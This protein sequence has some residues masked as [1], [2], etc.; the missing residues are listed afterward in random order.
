M[1]TIITGKPGHGKTLYTLH[2][3]QKTFADS[4]RPIYQNG[5]PDL[6][7]PWL[8]LE[9]PNLWYEL[10]EGSVIVIDEAQRIF[11]NRH[12]SAAVPQKVREFET[13][14]H[15]GFDVILI[16]QD[17]SLIDFAVRKLAGEHFHVRRP[18]GVKYATVS[19]WE[20]CQSSPNRRDA[21]EMAVKERWR[22]PKHLFDQYRS[23]TLHT[24]QS[25]LPWPRLILIGI[26][27]LAVPILFY[28]GLSTL[29]GVAGETAESSSAKP[30]AESPQPLMPGQQQVIYAD[31]HSPEAVERYLAQL[32]A[33]ASDIP[34]S[35]PLYDALI[36]E[37]VQVPVIS[38]CMQ[39]DKPSGDICTCNDQQGNRLRISKYACQDFMRFGFFNPWS[40][41]T[42]QQ[43]FSQRQ[44]DQRSADSGSGSGKGRED[45]TL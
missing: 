25:K 15:K 3:V 37:V 30:P 45:V 40:E 34:Y 19:K 39:I 32:R 10:P 44:T 35:A 17:P 11:P 24:H 16:T 43:D 12:T 18:F 8:D 28:V 1:L 13:H 41:E 9:N 29:T 14:R 5:I 4:G 22:Y 42:N 31:P 20:E 23:A 2:H 33:R 21:Q 38:G 6:K 27:V 36:R 7:L 26:G